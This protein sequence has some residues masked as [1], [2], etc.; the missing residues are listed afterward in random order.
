M[1]SIFRIAG[2][3]IV[4]LVA[5][6]LAPTAIADSRISIR[7]AGVGVDTSV[8]TNGDN[9]AISVD[10][11]RGKG[12]F[13]DSMLAISAE[14]TPTLDSCSEKYSVKFDLVYSAA[15]ITFPDL[16]QLFGIA[17]AN[18]GWLCLNPGTGEYYG[19]VDGIYAGGTG[20]F[21]SAS[22][23][24]SSPFSGIFLDPAIGFRSITGSVEGTVSRK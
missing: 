1:K 15:V 18:E 23:S 4:A 16:S 2:V 19:Q 22:G 3:S 5:L 8:D 10:Q 6:A 12:T 14:F 13:G 21:A 17:S 11:A 7:Y 9:F 20:R 24:F